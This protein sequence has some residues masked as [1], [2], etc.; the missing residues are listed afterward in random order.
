METSLLLWGL[1]LGSI[2]FVYFAYGKKRQRYV[3]MACGAALMGT[4]YITGN[5]TLLLVISAA[6]MALP[7]LLPN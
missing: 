6:L 4:P 1:L 2:G 7:F 5:V 3:S